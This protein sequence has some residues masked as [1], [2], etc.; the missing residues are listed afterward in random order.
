M[1]VAHVKFHR[2]PQ[3]DALGPALKRPRALSMADS[4]VDA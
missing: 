2:A 3:E 4:L 1:K